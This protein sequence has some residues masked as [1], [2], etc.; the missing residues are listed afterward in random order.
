MIYWGD[1]VEKFRDVF[2]KHGAVVDITSLIG[3]RIGELHRN[4][5]LIA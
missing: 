5:R 2:I 1:N 4:L 3:K